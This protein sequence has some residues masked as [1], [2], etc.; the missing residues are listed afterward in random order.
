MHLPEAPS[1]LLN[2]HKPA[3]KT[4]FQVVA[5]VRRWSGQRRV[6]HGGTL[7]P[8]ASGVLVLGLGQGTRVLEYLAQERKIYRAEIELGVTTDTYDGEGNV[9]RRADTQGIG[10]E[11]IAKALSLFRGSIEQVP[12]LYSA[13]KHQG[14]PLYRWAREGV[15]VVRKPRPV[16][17]FRLDLLSFQL[18][19][20]ALEIE[21]S[22]GTYIRSLAHDL[23]QTM[24]CGAYLKNLVR[25]RNG[26]FRLEDSFTLA[27]AE[28]A[29][30]TG[31]GQ[32]L[33]QPIDR[34]LLSFP[35][36][37]LGGEEERAVRAGQP[38][39]LQP[40]G[41][42][43]PQL[44]RAYSQEGRLV[45]L[46]GFEAGLWRPRKVLASDEGEAVGGES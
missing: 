27:Q 26:P 11:T 28:D 32:A 43:P 44:C 20:L 7:D 33:L 30:L 42:P 13:L 41:G 9:I 25:V 15:E 6:G 10:P 37:Y 23:G 45:A 4:S 24:G 2:L 12:P 16:Q 19:Y 17:V 1:G 3:G 35:A 34:A 31:R 22:K 36:V 38:L 39:S 21:C 18:P 8:A 46:L 14:R 40:Q 5:L 29:F